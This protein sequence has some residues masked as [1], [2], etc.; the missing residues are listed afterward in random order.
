[1]LTLERFVGPDL[2]IIN[3]HRVQLRAC[4]NRT[5]PGSAAL[6]AEEREH[7]RR[8]SRGRRSSER[9]DAVDVEGHRPGLPVDAV[10]VPARDVESLRQVLD[11]LRGRL[12]HVPQRLRSELVGA[13]DDD[14]DDVDLRRPCLVV[15]QPK[16]SDRADDRLNSD[17]SFE[18]AAQLSEGLREQLRRDVRLV[19]A[20]GEVLARRELESQVQVAAAD[21]VERG[22]R[23]GRVE[24]IDHPSLVDHEPVVI[25][26]EPARWT[27]G[28]TATRVP[29]V[30]KAEAVEVVRERGGRIACWQC[31]DTDPSETVPSIP[32]SGRGARL[33]IDDAVDVS[34]SR[35][36]RAAGH[37][38]AVL[39]DVAV[40]GESEDVAVG[41][42]DEA[43]QQRVRTLFVVN[44]KP[45][46]HHV[47]RYY[48]F[49][50]ITINYQNNE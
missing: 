19:P 10:G 13:L 38:D 40:G 31:S 46:F 17:A 44:V 35:G 45:Y 41:L 6:E 39:L 20:C 3:E 47:A 24:R 7:R 16:R 33:A 43:G 29:G 5:R 37:V 8:V 15:H 27:P 36:A 21:R 1:M 18:V 30:V 25:R 32:G 22:D 23:R 11:V 49:I 50:L 28:A 12:V 4:R 9:G 14:L 48:L 34:D 26:R 42:R 2:D